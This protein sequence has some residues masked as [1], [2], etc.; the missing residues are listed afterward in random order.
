M[1]ST[2]IDNLET[3]LEASKMTWIK[4]GSVYWIQ[5]ND[6]L[7]GT[8]VKVNDDET[9]AFV[10]NNKGKKYILHEFVEYLSSDP[11]F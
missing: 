2:L 9:L 5:K 7:I 6:K 11:V 1:S 10:N 4:I 8:Y 3:V